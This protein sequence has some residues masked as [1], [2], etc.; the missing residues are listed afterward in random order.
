M[1][2]SRFDLFRRLPEEEADDPR[3]DA[4]QQRHRPLR[5][6]RRRTFPE[7]DPD[8]EAERHA[9]PRERDDVKG[10]ILPQ[11]VLG[12]GSLDPDARFPFGWFLARRDG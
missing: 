4:R 2:H 7:D 3:H 10:T 6:L 11:S 12:L 8:A 9:D 5:A 1:T